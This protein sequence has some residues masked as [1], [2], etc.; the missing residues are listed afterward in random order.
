VAVNTRGSPGV[1]SYSQDD[2]TRRLED[3]LLRQ[4]AC[5]HVHQTASRHDFCYGGAVHDERDSDADF[6][7]VLL[8]R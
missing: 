7:A 4:C 8:F 1:I 5:G 3:D 6:P 2:S